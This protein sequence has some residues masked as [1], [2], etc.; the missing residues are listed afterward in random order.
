MSGG[1]VAVN[2][3]V[4][5]LPSEWAV[6]GVL[7]AERDPDDG[8][9]VAESPVDPKQVPGRGSETVLAKEPFTSDLIEPPRC[10]QDRLPVSHSDVHWRKS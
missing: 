3:T 9:R 7:V 1:P 4:E 6:A 10:P 5:V 2:P 8:L